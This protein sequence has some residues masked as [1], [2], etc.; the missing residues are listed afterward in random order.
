MRWILLFAF[1]CA[2]GMGCAAS[3]PNLEQDLN[4][5]RQTVSAKE[6]RIH[7]QQSAI[8]QKEQTIARKNEAISSL[9]K[10]VAELNRRLNISYSEQDRYDE[11]I[12]GVTSAVRGYIKQQI[13]EHRTF[14]TDI[15]LEDFLGNPLIARESMDEENSMIV[16]LAHPVPAKGQVNGV[17]GY[18]KG[19]GEIFVKL[20]RPVG[21]DYIVTYSKVL[22]VAENGEGKQLIDFDKPILA[23]EGDIVAY[24]LAGPVAV[25]Y[26]GKIGISSYFRMRE[27]EYPAGER[28]KADDILLPKQTKRKYSLNYYGIFV[29]N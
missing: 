20:L 28:L 2:A 27:D 4:A 26:D 14:L 10:R 1:I 19:S 7:E 8:E 13:Q 5:C 21:E 15:A 11:R 12:R 17:G 16:D 25:A 29:D 24:Y 9:E 18:F 23:D 22:Q 6:Q 3:C